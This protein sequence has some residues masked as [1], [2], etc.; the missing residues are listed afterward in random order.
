MKKKAIS[1][2]RIIISSIYEIMYRDNDPEVLQKITIVVK[3]IFIEIAV[4]SRKI[5]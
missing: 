1:I 3:V 5:K 4:F 2:F